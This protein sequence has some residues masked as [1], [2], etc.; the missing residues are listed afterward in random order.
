MAPIDKVEQ[1]NRRKYYT[2]EDSPLNRLF[3]P[4]ASN[5]YQ[6][7]MAFLRSNQQVDYLPRMRNI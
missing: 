4:V 7:V 6:N 1:K 2:T 5:I 3:D